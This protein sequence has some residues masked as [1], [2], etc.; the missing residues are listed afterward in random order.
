MVDEKVPANSRAGVDVNACGE[1]GVLGHHTGNDRD[2]QEKQFVGNPADGN[3]VK[4]GIGEDDLVL[5]P[6]RGVAV[7]GR[8]YVGLQIVLDPGQLIEKGGGQLLAPRAA[9][10]LFRFAVVR[11]VQ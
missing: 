6:R 11:M 3:G 9:D 4:A 5:V 7:K 1:V 2:V 10:R 8:L